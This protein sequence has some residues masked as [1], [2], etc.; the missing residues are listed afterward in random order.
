MSQ[1]MN[2]NH[3]NGLTDQEVIA[4]SISKNSRTLSSEF[5]WWLPFFHLSYQ[6]LRMNTP[7]L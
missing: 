6:L 4:N 5:C 2:E 1:K 7:K 3:L